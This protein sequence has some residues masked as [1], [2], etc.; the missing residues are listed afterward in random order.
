M[1]LNEGEKRKAVI[2]FRISANLKAAAQRAADEDSRSVSSLVIKLLREHL[3][4]RGYLEPSA[5]RPES[6]SVAAGEDR[7]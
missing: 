5:R 3:T 4:A 2:N 1:S 7:A 6:E